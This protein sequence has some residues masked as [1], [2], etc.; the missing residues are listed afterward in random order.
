MSDLFLFC[1]N[2]VVILMTS[3]FV[4]IL[5]VAKLM[6][7]MIRVII[8]SQV[9]LIMIVVMIVM[10][11]RTVSVSHILEIVLKYSMWWI[12]R[13]W[14]WYAVIDILMHEIVSKIRI[15]FSER[16]YITMV[17]TDITVFESSLFFLPF[18]LDFLLLSLPIHLL[19][20]L[21]L[22]DL[23]LLFLS[24]Q[25]LGP[26]IV[27]WLTVDCVVLMYWLSSEML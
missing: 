13:V 22:L 20:T 7:V 25:L 12:S 10:V 24:L 16:V 14:D 17:T 3:L 2:L 26:S 18:S 5:M 21:L 4:C 8:S 15:S 27:S 19:L 23:P 11:Y 9:M 6:S 1:S